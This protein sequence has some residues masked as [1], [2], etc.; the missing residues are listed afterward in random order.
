ML[1]SYSS[2]TSV[3]GIRSKYGIEVLAGSNPTLVHAVAVALE[4]LDAGLVKQCGI[5]YLG[6]EDLGVSQK[7]GPNHGYC[8]IRG[9]K[10]KELVLNTQLVDDPLLFKDSAGRTMDRFQHTLYHELGHGWDYSKGE[11]SME[12]DW[13]LL[14]GWSQYGSAGKVRVV[15]GSDEL[16]E[17]LVGRWYYDPN[18]EFV[19][20]YARLDPYEDMA[21]TFAF[22]VSGLHEFVPKNKLDF[23]K[24]HKVV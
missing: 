20:F 23:F 3:Q 14:S 7:Y 1:Q 12:D 5:G 24:K 2:E 17:E 4:K 21:D 9:D 19:R 6:F 8:R 16:D 11:I 22:V 13:L 15:V 10:P 18:A